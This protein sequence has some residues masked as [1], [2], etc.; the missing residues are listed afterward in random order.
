MLAFKAWIKNKL[1]LTSVKSETKKNKTASLE[2]VSELNKLFEQE[3]EVL[4]KVESELH[5][6]ELKNKSTNK[7]TLS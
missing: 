1:R 3:L 4:K 7:K 2:D 6:I 5:K